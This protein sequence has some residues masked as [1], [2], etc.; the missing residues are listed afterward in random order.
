[1]HVSRRAHPY[2]CIRLEV[3]RQASRP[4]GGARRLAGAPWSHRPSRGADAHGRAVPW[5]HRP[6]RG[7]ALAPSAL[8][9]STGDPKRAKNA[10][11]DLYNPHAPSPV[12]GLADC[13]LCADLSFLWPLVAPA[14]VF[15]RPIVDAWRPIRRPM[16]WRPIAVAWRHRDLAFRFIS[17][18]L[19][20]ISVGVALG[21]RC[22]HWSVL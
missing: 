20:L 12:V 9:R 14:L 5:G 6:S 2:L 19:R 15:R 18:A 1:M 16:V 10:F 7:P 21:P 3:A 13:R 4:L 22:R 17:A 11:G 8:G